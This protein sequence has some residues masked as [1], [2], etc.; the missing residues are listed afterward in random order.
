M[1][2]HRGVEL[3]MDGF[4]LVNWIFFEMESW[5]HCRQHL[6]SVSYHPG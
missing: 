2:V 3:R 5:I 4:R 1:A 6:S